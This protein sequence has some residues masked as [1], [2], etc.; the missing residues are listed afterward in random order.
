R[1][2]TRFRVIERFADHT[3]VEAAP[4]TGRQHQI[5]V[6]LASLGHPIVGDKIYRAS[7]AHFIAFC[8]GGLTPELLAAFDGLPRQA[9]HA[10]ELTFP[11]PI[12]RQPFTIQSRLPADLNDYIAGLAGISAA[13]SATGV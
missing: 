4:E 9:L 5:R 7:E 13:I 1:A 11:H 10:H 12:T 2:V 3:L 8:D 6:H